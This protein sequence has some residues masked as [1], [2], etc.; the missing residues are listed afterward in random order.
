[1]RCQRWADA[2]PR[3]RPLAGV[4]EWRVARLRAIKARDV[5][6]ASFVL[7]VVAVVVAGISVIYA[8]RQ[9]VE[10]QK[11]TAIGQRRFHAELRPGIE[12]TCASR[13]LEPA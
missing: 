9:A 8:G 2:R 6:S 13:G 3:Q 11:V 4:A 12:L 7:S 10:A 1:M 5:E